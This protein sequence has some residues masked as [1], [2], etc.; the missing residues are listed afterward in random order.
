VNQQDTGGSLTG[1]FFDFVGVAAVVAHGLAAETA[2]ILERRIVD[3]HEQDFSGDIDA[4]VIVPALFRGVDSIADEDEVSGDVEG[5]FRFRC[6]GD[7]VRACAEFLNDS[8]A[9]VGSAAIPISS[10]SWK[11]GAD[12]GALPGRDE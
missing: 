12:P 11:N 10:T 3:Q 2:L 1:G 7:E 4:V 9:V 8:L 6:P 5:A